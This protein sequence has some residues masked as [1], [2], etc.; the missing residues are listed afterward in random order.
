[1]SITIIARFSAAQGSLPKLV[2]GVARHGKGWAC[3]LES[4]KK[5]VPRKT[6]RWA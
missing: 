6:G 5:I 1:V 4:E 2:F 3:G